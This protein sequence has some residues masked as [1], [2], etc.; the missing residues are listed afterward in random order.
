MD[1]QSYIKMGLEGADPLNTSLTNLSHYPSIE[2]TK[3]DLI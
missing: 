1:Y 2:I 3:E